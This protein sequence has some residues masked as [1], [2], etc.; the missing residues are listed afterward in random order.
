MTTQFDPQRYEA[1]FSR[2]A[3]RVAGQ[4]SVLIDLPRENADTISLAFGDADPKWFPQHR[5]NQS[6]TTLLA[7]HVDPFMNYA[8]VDELLTALVTQRLERR[9]VTVN[10]KQLLIT[11]GSSQV[12][13]LLPTIMLEPGDTIIVEGPTFLGAVEYFAAADARIETIPVG[14]D[15]MDLDVLEATLQRLKHHNIRPKFIYSIPTYQNPTGTLMSAA[16]RARLVAL[17]AQY[18]VLLIEDDAYGELSYSP[19]DVPSMLTLPG[20]EWVLHIGTFSKILAPGVRMAWAYGPA[21]VI[22]RLQ[23]FKSESDCGTFITRLVASMASDGWLDAHIADLRTVYAG[24]RDAMQQAIATHFPADVRTTKP[25][26]G[27]FVYGY[28]PSDLPARELITHAIAH[29]ASF[30]PG[31]TG[32]ANGGGTHEMRLAF[33]YQSTERIVDGIARLGAAMRHMR[34]HQSR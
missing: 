29:G 7:G 9:G 25:T 20:S 18:E 31:T 4:E 32:Y 22:R 16:N 26:G 30:L 28:L 5:F 24:K 12:L 6:I 11:Y 13:G 10:Q 17:A 1:L 15:G 3:R 14:P 34:E 27:F 23:R 2:D 33:S 19:L 21:A 8:P